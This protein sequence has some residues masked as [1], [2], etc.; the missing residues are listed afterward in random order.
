MLF[1]STTDWEEVTYSLYDMKTKLPTVRFKLKHAL[2]R[3]KHINVV[4]NDDNPSKKMSLKA[5]FDEKI[6]TSVMSPDDRKAVIN[7]FTDDVL[8]T[9][10]DM[11]EQHPNMTEIEC[12]NTQVVIFWEEAFYDIE[13][14]SEIP[15]GD[16]YI[17]MF[18]VM[19]EVARQI[20]ENLDNSIN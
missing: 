6:V 17:E 4:D 14:H 2:A 16:N 12:D 10:Y 1:R 19:H 11:F 3:S 7:L 9:I 15:T 20:G 13:K 5:G 18:D 8:S